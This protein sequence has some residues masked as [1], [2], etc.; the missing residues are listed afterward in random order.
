ML[1]SPATTKAPK[2]AD[3]RGFSLLFPLNSTGQREARPA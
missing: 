2:I 3:F 1:P